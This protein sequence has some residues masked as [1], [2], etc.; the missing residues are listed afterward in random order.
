[1]MQLQAS[2][3]GTSGSNADC[4]ENTQYMPTLKPITAAMMTGLLMRG[5]MDVTLSPRVEEKCMGAMNRAD[6]S[7][8]YIFGPNPAR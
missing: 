1:M 5:K 8:G 7:S 4:A 3:D 6:K 2:S